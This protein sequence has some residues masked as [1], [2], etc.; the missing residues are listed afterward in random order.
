MKQI[1]FP[2]SRGTHPLYKRVDTQWGFTSEADGS[3]EFYYE[4]RINMEDLHHL[5]VKAARNKSGKAK[6]GPLSVK[7][8]E[9]R[10]MP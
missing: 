5:A 7:V 3:E 4:T 2:K 8:I 1:I 10:R 9:R 6:D